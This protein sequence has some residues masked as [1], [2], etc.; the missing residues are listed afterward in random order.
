MTSEVFVKFYQVDTV[1]WKMS[2]LSVHF[3]GSTTSFYGPGTHEPCSF[4]C[5]RR[6]GPEFALQER[7]SARVSAGRLAAAPAPRGAPS[8]PGP[9]GHGCEGEVFLRHGAA[10]LGQSS[11][12]RA[13]SV[14]R[15]SPVKAESRPRA[16]S[17]DRL[18]TP[19]CLHRFR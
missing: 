18:Q 11:L 2:T 14:P 15:P 13:R 4:S 9:S 1:W 3:G 17:A 6:G 5:G 19:W 16:H 8:P 12:R 10:S 7:G